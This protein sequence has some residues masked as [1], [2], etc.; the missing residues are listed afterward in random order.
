MHNL[1]DLIDAAIY[2]SPIV[3]L[4]LALTRLTVFRA[5]H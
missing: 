4:A 5:A 3:I 2:L 1:I